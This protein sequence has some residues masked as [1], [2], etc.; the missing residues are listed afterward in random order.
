MQK[1]LEL[2]PS[3]LCRQRADHWQAIQSAIHATLKKMA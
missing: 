2:N 3:L 1:P